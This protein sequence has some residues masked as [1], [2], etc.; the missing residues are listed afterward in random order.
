M[1]GRL[2]AAAFI[3]LALASTP[4]AAQQTSA[5]SVGPAYRIHPGDEIEIMVW[6]DARLQR[7][8]RVL[9]DG[10]IAFPL[11]G[12]IVAGGQLPTDIE[13]LIT[14]ALRPQYRGAVPQVTVMVKNPSGYQFSVIGKVQSP[15][16]FTPGRY[17]N[18]LEAISIAG[19]PTQFAQLGNVSI[20]RHNGGQIHRLPVR[21]N[22]A[23]SG[24]VQQ[25]GPWDVPPIVGGD[26]IIVP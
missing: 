5:A 15:G 25:L 6:G 23:L 21:L 26:T 18:A 20:V 13:R 22:R 16:T 2:V 7:I 8:L 24:S 10:T 19:G 11:A 1:C 14:A 3:V 9:P 12:Q 17:V 4:G